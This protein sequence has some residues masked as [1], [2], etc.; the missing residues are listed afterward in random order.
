M[1]KILRFVLTSAALVLGLAQTAGA[2]DEGIVHTVIYVE[3]APS[4]AAE[5]AALIAAYAG[6][7]RDA[8]GNLQSQAL[9]RIGRSSHFAILETWR[10]AEALQAHGSSAAAVRARDA[11]EPLLYS[12][13]DVRL[14]G[15]LAMADGG[16]VGPDGVFVVTHVD[17]VPANT[18][19]A[20]ELLRTLASTSRGDAGNVRFDVLV[21]ANRSNH[22]TVVEAWESRETRDAHYGAD[23]TKAFRGSLFPLS[24]ALYDERLYRAL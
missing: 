9:Q 10:D 23:H 19:V 2:Q 18:D 16:T 20:H 14:H 24:G 8:D 4:A 1:R 15:G 13:P 21:Q 6:A 12:P 22:M 11:L 7:S 17:V 3:V 5:A